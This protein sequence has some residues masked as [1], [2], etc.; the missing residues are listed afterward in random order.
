MIDAKQL[1]AAQALL[2]S[3]PDPPELALARG[4]LAEAQGDP[5][6]ALSIYNVLTHRPDPLVRIRAA[7]RAIDLRLAQHMISEAQAADALDGLVAAWHGG[8]IEL[9]LR[10]Q[11]SD[12]RAKNGQWQNALDELRSLEN[13]FPTEAS[14]IRERRRQLFAAFIASSDAARTLAARLPHV[15][16]KQ[17]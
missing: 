14:A 1:A 15:C 3:D 4:M 17:H 11:L 5:K 10:E 16:T 9:N 13:D 2:K 12:L 7:R 8:S 6:T